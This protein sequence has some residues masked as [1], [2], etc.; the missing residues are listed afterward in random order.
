MLRRIQPGQ[1]N[2]S[3]TQTQRSTIGYTGN[4]SKWKPYP[5]SRDTNIPQTITILPY[6]TPTIIATHVTLSLNVR[7][8]P[9]PITITA[10]LLLS[11]PASFI[12]PEPPNFR[13]GELLSLS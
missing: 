8:L 9:S 2:D 7:N 1:A 12:H 13:S 11:V 3:S 10:Q 4:D 5:S 6:P